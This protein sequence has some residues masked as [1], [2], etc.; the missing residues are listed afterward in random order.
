MFTKIRIENFK[1]L[2]DIEIELGQAVVFIGPNNSGKTSALQ[3]LALW[4]TGLRTWLAK[5]GVQETTKKRSGVTINRKDLIAL[6]APDAKLLWRNLHVRD[7]SR[8]DDGKQKTRNVLIRITVE[9][10]S[11]GQVW[12]C[13][14]EFD[15]ANSEALFCRP[16]LQNDGER[17]AIPAAARAARVA[18]LPPMSGLASVE[19]K[20][21]PGRINVLIGEG[22]TA[23]VLRNLCWRLYSEGELSRAWDPL[24]KHIKD[25]FGVTLQ[26][27][28]YNPLRGEITMSY[29]EYNVE[30]DL[31]S[32]GRGLQ[33]TFLLLAYLYANPKTALLLDEPDAHLEILR[34]RQIY[35][36]VNDIAKEQGGQIIAASHSEVVLNEAAGKDVVIA[37]VGHPHRL[38]DKD[39]GNQV[40][41]SLQ[42]IGFD[43]YYLAEE[44]GWV[45]YLEGS[46]DL[47]ILQA[48]AKRL[49]HPANVFLSDAFVHYVATNLPNRARDHYYGLREAKPDLRG[50]AIF[51]RLSSPLEDSGGLSEMMWQRR[52]IENYLC[53]EDTLLAFA[54]HSEQDDLFILAEAEHRVEIMKECINCIRE[55][56]A[57]LDKPL[58]WSA[59]IKSTDDFLNPLFKLY[60][61][62]LELPASNLSKS[63]YHQLAEFLPMEL[64]DP[65]IGEKLDKVVEV[66]QQAK[67]PIN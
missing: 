6:T 63:N 65:E 19:P 1:R 39:R 44:K 55:S 16:L 35:K 60:F 61:N 29:R 23:Q 50:L 18:F 58:P 2:G 42:T 52:E 51:D 37:F 48:F 15:Y 43:Q 34:Q 28:Q 11:E 40:L 32:A 3:A 4:E 27:P 22:Q 38:N 17:I 14:L 8:G 25:L 33:Q 12:R 64:I 67:K 7:V 47:A 30:L 57:N 24:V 21:E 46:T 54:R 56:L 31:S 59:D 53:Y 13:G 9:G 20:L 5:R 49:S 41:K 10:V 62:K 36:M 45:L 26:P 66:A